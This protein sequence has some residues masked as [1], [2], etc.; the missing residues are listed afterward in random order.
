MR[1][2]KGPENAVIGPYLRSRRWVNLKVTPMEMPSAGEGRNNVPD[3]ADNFVTFATRRYSDGNLVD[4][5]FALSEVSQ[6]IDD[7]KADTFVWV[8]FCRPSIDL[9]EQFGRQLGLHE[10]AI[11]IAIEQIGDG[12]RRPKLDEYDDHLLAVCHSVTTAVG[13]NELI[14]SEIDV[15]VHPRCL[16]TVRKDD[17]FDINAVAQRLQ[18]SRRL[19]RH[20]VGYVLYVLLDSIVSGYFAVVQSFDD[21]YDGVADGLFSGTPV[22]VD[23]QRAWFET[24]RALVAFHRLVVPMRE[25]VNALSRRDYESI[26][27]AL[28]PYFR[29]VHD[30]LLRISESTESL[31]DL[32]TT[33]VETNLS[34]REYRQSQVMKKVSSWAAIVAVPTL[35]T[36]FYGMNVPYP[37]S[38]TQ[39][40]AAVAGGLTVGLSAVLYWLFR[41]RD[42][43]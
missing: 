41:Q 39:S 24:R 33:I 21:Y 17:S 4:E 28:D 19:T 2:T 5:G 12:H 38:G 7:A 1:S 16:I 31:R 27:V 35:V 34:L 18:H 11:D 42:W 40:G 10:I 43:L 20:G 25:L 8:D 3:S 15:F 22:P 13:T 26:P 6:Y 23:Q 9:V 37:G 36:G 32:S 30:D 14:A 29:D